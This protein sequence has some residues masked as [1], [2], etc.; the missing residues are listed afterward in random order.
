MTDAQLR[1]CPQPGLPVRLEREADEATDAV[2]D[3]VLEEIPLY[4]ALDA[5]QLADVRATIRAGYLFTLRLWA[6]GELLTPEQLEPFRANGATRAA[7]GRPLPLVLRA[8]RVSCIGVYD[9]IVR[10]PDVRLETEDEQNF[11]R[12][13]MYVVDQLS[14]EVTIGYVETTGQLGS[15]QGR[16]RR[17]LLD[18]LLTG[19]LLTQAEL[20]ERATTLGLRL[21]E[22]PQL[23]VAAAAVGE[24]SDLAARARQALQDLGPGMGLQLIA[25]GQL[26]VVD[27]AAELAVIRRALGRAGLT[28][29]VLDVPDLANVAAAYQRA[30]EVHELMRTA[31]LPKGL[32]VGHDDAL[33]LALLA[34]AREDDLAGQ[35]TSGIL[36]DLPAHPAL[37][38]TLDAYLLTGN[39]TSA[40]HSLGI[41]HQT[42]RYRLKRIREITDRDPTQGFDRFLLELALRISPRA[43][44]A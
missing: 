25:R 1:P 29:V 42:M 39:A 12:L 40:A 8:Y 9:Y 3:R 31:A 36:R 44:P 23:L 32:T 17:E 38:E 26:V 34:R 6:A 30:R 15:Q 24:G 43:L 18:D 11:A 4:R 14:N 2:L 10:H 27:E 19:R 33:A 7:E 5:V 28:G 16:A 37:L 20:T 21:P 35:V 41:H 22:H 13:A